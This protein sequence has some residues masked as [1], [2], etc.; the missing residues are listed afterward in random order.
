MYVH[1][2]GEL[3]TFRKRYYEYA[4]PFGITTKNIDFVQGYKCIFNLETVVNQICVNLGIISG[5][6]TTYRQSFKTCP[7]N[8]T[9]VFELFSFSYFEA[10]EIANS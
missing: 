5:L 6:H 2:I 8:T 10:D 1:S 9:K 7:F 3:V 4:L